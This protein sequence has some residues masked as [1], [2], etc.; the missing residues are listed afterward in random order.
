[1]NVVIFGLGYVGSAAA[2][3]I[4]SQ[5][6]TIIGVDVS[7]AKVAALNSGR[8]PV[9][10]PGL[11]E[12]IAAA[13]AD[14]RIKAVTRV[15]DELDNCDIAIVCVGTPSG[16]DGAHDMSFIAQVTRE[17]AAA[18]KPD[19]ASPLTL[20][21]RSTMRPGSC[22]NI[23]WPIIESHL[24]A[25]AEKTVELVYNPEFLREASAI[26]DFFHPPKI[27]IGTL[28]GKPSAN[29]AKLNEGINAPVF[30][31]GLREAEITKFV[32]NS[33]HA[34][35]VAFANEIG[36]V[37]QNLGISASE[38]HAIF[39][40]DTKLNLS[41]YYTRPGG[42]F[43][44]SCLPKDVRALQYIAADTG[45]A[46]H[47]VDALIRSNEAH[48][49]H[50]FLHATQGLEA[51]ARVLLVG[52]AFK[53][54]TDD[55]RESPAVDMA[56]KLLEAGYDVDIYDPKVAPSS[57]VGQNLGYA[58]SVLP[59]IDDLMVTQ[60]TAESR[61]YARIIATNRLIDT[62][63]IDRTKLVDTSAIA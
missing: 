59:R 49:H 2:G 7:D 47:L 53:L 5:G 33:W 16:V 8:A 63:A 21:Y 30:E 18:L 4:A 41:A 52:L 46:T 57:L 14:G 39:K 6:H 20:V 37:C 19:R 13:H 17:I 31:V 38:V 28:G 1:M 44:G 36:R 34:V 9:Y 56:R 40:S 26:E 27:V 11:D 12:L 3:C 61:E 45:S 15:S 35:K 43:G 23:I 32:D 51:G 54:E 55:L 48:K 25:E 58:Y 24:G 60:Q 10:E 29:M 62:L 50:Q 22:E 42:P